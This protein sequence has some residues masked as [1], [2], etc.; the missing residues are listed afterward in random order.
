MFGW[1]AR[2]VGPEAAR[3]SDHVE[4][5]AVPPGKSTAVQASGAAGAPAAI[6]GALRTLHGHA[7]RLRGRIEHLEA[8]A[9]AGRAL[10]DLELLDVKGSLAWMDRSFEQVRVAG[11]GSALPPALEASIAAAVDERDAVRARVVPLVARLEA[12]ATPAGREAANEAAV[13]ADLERIEQTIPAS[14][15]KLGRRIDVVRARRSSKTDVAARRKELQA[16]LALPTDGAQRAAAREEYEAIEWVAHER[17]IAVPADPEQQRAPVGAGGVRWWVPSTPEAMRAF[18]EREVTAAGSFSAGRAR[19]WG[20]IHSP[21]VGATEEQKDIGD[22]QLAL[23]DRD[24]AAF[25]DAFEKQNRRVALGMLDESSRVIDGVLTSYGIPGGTHRM[26]RA[27]RVVAD[28]PD[29]V[30]AQ[31]EEWTEL[32]NGSGNRAAR[33]GGTGQREDLAKWIHVIEHQRG[34]VHELTGQQLDASRRQ[35]NRGREE[36]GRSGRDPLLDRPR[37]DDGSTPRLTRDWS[38]RV[39]PASYDGALAVARRDLKALWGK[40]EWVHPILAAYRTGD[41]DGH[42][43]G[44]SAAPARR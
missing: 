11:S 2:H 6:A 23:I 19:A 33:E 3:S 36:H 17:G 37:Y 9:D 35:G 38:P 14:D 5:A 24:A 8:M 28:D 44:S 15:T 10:P 26:S 30:E 13:A 27:A 12:L 41:G 1:V 29:A 16:L 34:V 4:P 32:A 43:T 20:L 42:L 7:A 40:A 25:G 31:V 39:D 22:R 21:T 18:I